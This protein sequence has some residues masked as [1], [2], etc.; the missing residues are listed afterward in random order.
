MAV[1]FISSWKLPWPLPEDVAEDVH[2]HNWSCDH[3]CH[4]H[5]IMKVIMNPT[6][7][8]MLQRVCNEHH[9]S[10]D[11]GC[12]IHYSYHHDSYHDPYLSML[13]RMCMNTTCDHGCHIHII[14][15]VIMTPTWGCCRGCAWRQLIWE[16]QPSSSPPDVAYSGG[17]LES[18][19]F[20]CE[21]ICVKDVF[22]LFCLN[23]NISDFF[24]QIVPK[25]TAW[26]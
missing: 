13:Q 7:L 20:F 17:R 18:S 2:E 6:N 12:H 19:E 14:M 23:L 22:V 21:K 16:W 25:N 1:I 9:W 24:T 11:H 10:C 15:K 26:Q 8:R 3:G 5:I 4:I